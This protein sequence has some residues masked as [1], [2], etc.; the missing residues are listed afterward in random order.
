[1]RTEKGRCVL[2]ADRH[3]G[4]TESLRGLL[5]TSFETV[6]MV[7]D[8]ESLFQTASRL[9][10]TIAVVD[11]SIAQEASFRWLRKLRD[12]C[13]TL[14]ILL[15]GVHDERSVRTAALKAGADSFVPKRAIATELLPAVDAMLHEVEA[16]ESLTR[17]PGNAAQ[18][19]Q[20]QKP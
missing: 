5:E 20:T 8:V 17:A 6:V 10:P 13:P 15:I 19:P 16:A 9:L 11:A 3:H 7:A 14:K 12:Q 1:M 18:T 2:L 4:V